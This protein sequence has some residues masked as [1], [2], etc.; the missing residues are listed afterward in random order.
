MKSPNGSGSVR[1]RADGRWEGRFVAPDGKQRSV[2][3]RTKSACLEALRR[4]Q[5]EILAGTYIEPSRLTLSEW[6]DRWIADYTPTIKPSTRV[7]YSRL[8]S[9][10]VA[11]KLGRVRLERLTA[12]QLQAFFSACDLAPSTLHTLKGCLSSALSCAVRYD[13]IPSNPCSKV[14]LQTAQKRE[15]T[16]IDRDHIPAFY[17]ACAASRYGDALIVLFETGMRSSEL[18]GLRWSDVDLDA[19]TLTVSRQ[20][21]RVRNTYALQTPKSGKPRVIALMPSTLEV[22]RSMHRV[23]AAQRLSTGLEWIDDTLCHDLVL[24]TSAGRYVGQEALSY[25]CRAVGKE[26]GLPDLSPHDLRHSYAVAA[27]RA[28]IDIKTIQNALGHA[29]AAMTLDVYAAYT[30]DMGKAGAARLAAF[31]AEISPG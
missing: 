18:R 9:V 30:A 24:R 10:H 11:P 31:L 13:V 8:I 5:A 15:M 16:I 25:A 14:Q 29:R 23:Q 17:R 1:K 7:L 26:I 6:L 20:L 22:L 28:G 2:Y 27:I 12:A 21:C 3:A 4:K 19:A